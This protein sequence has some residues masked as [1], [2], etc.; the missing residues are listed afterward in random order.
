MHRFQSKFSERPGP[1]S[2]GR[3]R[4]LFLWAAA[5]PVLSCGVIQGAGG[6][7]I[8]GAD[9][10]HLAFFES[11]GVTYKDG[12]QAQDCLQILKRH[13]LTCARLRLFTSSAAQAQANPYNYI[14]NLEYTLPLALRVKNAGLQFMLDFHYSDTWAD[15]GK[16]RKPAA[17]TNLSFAELKQQVRLYN[18]NCIAAFKTAGAMPDYVQV[19]NE[20]TS[21]MLWPDGKVGGTYDTVTQ[22]SQ[23]AQLITNA[24]S[25]IQDAA[26]EQ[27]PKIIIHIDR[28]GDWNGTQWFFDHLQQQGVPFDIIGLSYYPWWHG[29][30]GNL[31]NCVTNTAQKYSKPVILAE[32]AFPWTNSTNLYGIPASTNGQ[33]QFLGELTNIMKRLPA[34]LGAGIVWWG[35]EYQAVPGVNEGGFGQK[36]FFDAS[37][38]MLP[39]VDG[40]GQLVAPLRLNIRLP[41]TKP[42]W[43]HGIDQAIFR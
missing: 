38:N 5:L 37:G 31:A 23:L 35:A 14:N 15:P 10:S 17:W 8:S 1:A 9:V 3:V 18:S 13:G 29:S 2:K 28:G 27:M 11:R 36:S 34:N 19:G 42:H 6:N 41:G 16:Q 7:F 12:G 30:L 43:H 40:L 33:V 26:G 22:W 21:G 25:G 24:I 39:V 4:A 20:I 32:T